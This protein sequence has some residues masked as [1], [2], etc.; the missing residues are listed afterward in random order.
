MT[1]SD[2]RYASD[3]DSSTNSGLTES[4]GSSFGGSRNRPQS[5]AD[6]RDHTPAFA[7]APRVAHSPPVSPRSH[8]SCSG[9]LCAQSRSGPGAPK[10]DRSVSVCHRATTDCP[11]VPQGQNAKW[12]RV[13]QGQNGKWPRV[14]QGQEG[15]HRLSR[16]RCRDRGK[17]SG[18]PPIGR[19]AARRCPHRLLRRVTR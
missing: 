12:P 7:E 5:G 4:H 13:P 8:S 6:R 2:L 18:A 9:W 1:L 17:A 3:A 15:A 16:D 11:R 14:P 10:A 19:S